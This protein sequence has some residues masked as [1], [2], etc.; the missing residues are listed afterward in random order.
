MMANSASHT[1]TS[2]LIVD[3]PNNP[4]LL[5]TPPAIPEVRLFFLKLRMRTKRR[6]FLL[7]S[8]TRNFK[9]KSLTSGIAGGVA[10]SWGLFG[11]STI[12]CEVKVC[13]AEFAIIQVFRG[14]EEMVKS[15]IE[16]HLKEFRVVHVG[17]SLRLCQQAAV[18]LVG[19]ELLLGSEVQLAERE[20]ESEEKEAME[21]DQIESQPSGVK[22][23]L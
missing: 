14:T 7:Q 11:A 21:V 16:L 1:L 3:A 2:H 17:G 12:R 4:Q 18:K 22:V 19:R 5:A 20:D 23:N 8:S 10:K 9:K 6:Y 15:V 13:D